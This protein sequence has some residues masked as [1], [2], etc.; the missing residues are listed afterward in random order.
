M[1]AK[2]NYDR[3]EESIIKEYNRDGSLETIGGLLFIALAVAMAVWGGSAFIQL[4]VMAVALVPILYVT[5]F[6]RNRFTYPR[7][8][9]VQMIAKPQSKNLSPARSMLKWRT[10]LFTF[11]FALIF[12]S[13]WEFI[14]KFSPLPQHPGPAGSEF[15]GLAGRGF[16]IL[17]GTYMANWGIYSGM[18]GIWWIFT[19]VSFMLV[20]L[21]GY[22]HL[23][24]S[25]IVAP[26]GLSLLVFGLLQLRRFLHEYPQPEAP[27]VQAQ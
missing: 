27:D 17:I 5:R 18:N 16:A 2:E 14:W 19:A 4:G 10:V 8:G 12:A 7:L 24:P 23:Y 6:W 22:Y 13:A 1:S 25:W 3:A 20:V 15:G 26:I 21:A 9:Y 11:I